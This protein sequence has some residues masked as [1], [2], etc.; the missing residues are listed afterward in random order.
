MYPSSHIRMIKSKR[1]RWARHGRDEKGIQILYK[2]L[3]G[4]GPQE[5]HERRW[6]MTIKWMSSK[7]GGKLWNG[8]I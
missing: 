3:N 6:K 8:F 5:R 4:K 1:I 7:Y 2:K